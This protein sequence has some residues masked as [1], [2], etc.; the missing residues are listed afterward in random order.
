MTCG[1]WVAVLLQEL[2][3]DPQ[4]RPLT[5]MAGHQ[6]GNDT[7]VADTMVSAAGAGPAHL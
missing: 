3:R 5:I 7:K 2:L 4:L 6:G 1:S